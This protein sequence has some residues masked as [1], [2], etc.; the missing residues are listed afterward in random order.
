M[1]LAFGNA[2]TS[3]TLKIRSGGGGLVARHIKIETS[4]VNRNN[5]ETEFIQFNLYLHA[6]TPLNAQTLHPPDPSLFVTIVVK[7]PLSDD[8][9][10]VAHLFMTVQTSTSRKH[11]RMEGVNHLAWENMPEHVQQLYGCARPCRHCPA[12][13]DNSSGCSAHPR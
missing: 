13:A 11:N 3:D 12:R 9:A 7:A 6:F 2:L 1:D 4:I 8:H 10:I 5:T